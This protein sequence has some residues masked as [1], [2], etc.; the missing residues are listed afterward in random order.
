MKPQNLVNTRQSSVNK[1]QTSVNNTQGTVNDDQG[2]INE[3][4]TILNEK[5]RF[6]L[7]F[8]N[9]WGI[10]ISLIISAFAFGV[11]YTTMSTKLDNVIENQRQLSA[12][13]REWKTQAENRLGLVESRQNIVITYL[14]QHLG[15]DIR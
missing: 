7:K 4:Q 15:I 10:V 9:A 5:T 2:N 12:D 8:N 14:N 3:A 13:F 6:D 1:R 11:T